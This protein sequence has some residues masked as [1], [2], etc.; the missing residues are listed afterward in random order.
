MTD[1]RA[2]G[3][4]EGGS[5]TRLVEQGDLGLLHVFE[6]ARH[7][8]TA[9][10]SDEADA[11]SPEEFRVSLMEFVSGHDRH[12]DVAQ[13][14]RD[15]LTEEAFGF[16]AMLGLDDDVELVAE[17][18]GDGAPN[19][20]IVI[21]DENDFGVCQFLY[22]P[23]LGKRNP[24]RRK[25]RRPGSVAQQLALGQLLFH[26]RVVRGLVTAHDDVVHVVLAAGRLAVLEGQPELGRPVRGVYL[27]DAVDGH[28]VPG[29]RHAGAVDDAGQPLGRVD[30]GDEVRL[31]L[32]HRPIDHEVE[33]VGVRAAGGPLA[34]AV[35][36]QRP[37]GS[38]I[39]VVRGDLDRR[40]DGH[41]RLDRRRR[42]RR[43]DLGLGQRRVAEAEQMVAA[44][45]QT[46]AER[47]KHDRAADRQEPRPA[48]GRPVLDL[49][50]FVLEVV[51]LVLD[52]VHLGH[53]GLL[54]GS[55][56]ALQGLVHLRL[57]R[58][59][60]RGSPDDGFV[61][62]VGGGLQGSVLVVG[63]DRW[64]WVVDRLLRLPALLA[65]GVWVAD[66]VRAQAVQNHRYLDGVVFWIDVPRGG[67][68]T[69]RRPRLGAVGAAT[70]HDGRPLP[71][72]T[73]PRQS[74]SAGTAH[75][76]ALFGGMFGQILY[77]WHPPGGH[78]FLRDEL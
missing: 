37:F 30:A 31:L 9:A 51:H 63:H 7:D 14:E 61:V 41:G 48:R 36:D 64:R 53:V 44:A 74:L 15:P 20:R 45:D 21:D 75:A 5:V 57:S 59:D 22:F 8:G 28:G 25:K 69:T 1:V 35:Q 40:R 66:F 67:R 29:R 38:L 65:V 24:G 70:A 10:Q 11:V 49:G 23:P 58:Q 73:V 60:W 13:D 18:P 12:G 19:G 62:R 32:Q 27:R 55:A 34:T 17:C 42:G 6:S 2:N 46:G 77:A 68:E 4:Q 71:D 47:Q 16:L 52:V 39:V 72:G 56:P 3:L 50:D 78:R 76:I 26:A 33:A 54:G 43:F